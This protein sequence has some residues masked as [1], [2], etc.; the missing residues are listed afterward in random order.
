[1]ISLIIPV[2]KIDAYCH[3][4]VNCVRSLQLGNIEI[5]VEENSG[6]SLG[7]N[8]NNAIKKASGE[9]IILLHNDMVINSGFIECMDRDIVEG[10]ITSYTR[11]EPPIYSD[12][13]PGKIILDCGDSLENFNAD[14]F[15]SINVES[16]LSPGGTQLFFGCYKKDYIGL[17]G[18]LFDPM[19][20]EDD[21]LH[22]RYLLLGYD[23]QI[24]NA[25]VYHFVSKTSRFSTE[26]RDNTDKIEFNSNRNFIRKWGFRSS[27]SNK[28]YD[29]GFIIHN[30]NLPILE[31]L[32]PWCSNLY[33]SEKFT[34]GRAQD[35]IEMENSNTKFDLQ[36]RI[37]TDLYTHEP[38]PNNI[39]V[40]FDG[41]KLT[42]YS[43][44]IIQNLSDIITETN[45]LGTFELDIFKITIKSLDSYEKDLIYL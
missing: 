33:T 26:Y 36:S 21:D 29:I 3:N 10:R 45:E 35:Y 5:I 8:Y 42:Q 11:I 14:K 9:K 27:K 38:K 22:L 37:R 32:E 1:M 31:L 44:D 20:C 24:S 2:T 41:T 25:A 39:L 28:K 43:F 17:D 6:V 34:E 15:N 16:K 19:F 23:K 4:L 12:L 40:E 18:H 30:C 13:H 7:T